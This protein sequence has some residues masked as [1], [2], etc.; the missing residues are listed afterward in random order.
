MPL[1][2]YPIWLFLPIADLHIIQVSVYTATDEKHMR[3]HMN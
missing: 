3:L 1:L 2:R